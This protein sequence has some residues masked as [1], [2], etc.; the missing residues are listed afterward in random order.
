VPDPRRYELIDLF[1]GCGGMTRGFLDSKR[2]EAVFAVECDPDAAATYRANFGAHVSEVPI[3]NVAKFPSAGIVIGGPPC[4]GFSPLNRDVVGFERRGLWREYLR[5]LEQ[6]EPEAFVMENVPE[7]LASAEY[8]EFKRR[9]EEKLGFTVDQRI[10]NA[11]DYGVPQRRRRAIAIGVRSGSVPWP[12]PTHAEPGSSSSKGRKKWV[13]FRRAVKG[14]PLQPNGKKWHRAR[15]PRPFSV[16]RYKAVPRDGGN[17]FQMQKNLDK[18]GLGDLVPRCWREKPT[19]TTDVFGRLWWDKPALTIRTEFYKPEKGRY[20]HPSAHRP[21]T[22]REAARCMS[23]RDSFIFPEDQ[24]MTSVA[25]Q[26]GNA[27]PPLLARCIAETL[28]VHLDAELGDAVGEETAEAA[29]EQAA[30]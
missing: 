29:P 5:A 7:L 2:F 23:F 8:A 12:E 6:A 28:A 14:L 24:A 9:V 26:I 3:E 19:G 25:R 22:V 13:S 17:R 27:V 11:A 21:I 10:L 1:A 20:L 4:Q 16:R 18:A 30:A 15:S